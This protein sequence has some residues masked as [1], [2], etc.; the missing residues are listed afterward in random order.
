MTELWDINWVQGRI[1]DLRAVGPSSLDMKELAELYY[2][3]TLM[4]K[5][6]RDQEEDNN[7]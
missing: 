2:L 3:E 5:W 7:E 4:R 6:L 1:Q